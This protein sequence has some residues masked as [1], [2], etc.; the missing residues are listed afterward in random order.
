VLIVD[1]H[2]RIFSGEGH[3]AALVGVLIGFPASGEGSRGH[4]I[5]HHVIVPEVVLDGVGV[6]R[7]RLHQELLEVVCG[8]PRLTL[9]AD[10]T[11]VIC[12]LVVATGSVSRGCSLLKSLLVPLPA[13]LGT[14]PSILG[15]DFGRCPLLLL[16]SG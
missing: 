7:A 3:R 14:L 8:Q 9:A 5:L 4:E 10:H 13:A 2:D 6:I 16:G 1:R 12:L 15:G 11:G